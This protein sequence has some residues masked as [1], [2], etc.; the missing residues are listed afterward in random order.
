MS[1][2]K[3]DRKICLFK[4]YNSSSKIDLHFNLRFNDS[5]LE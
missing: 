3:I 5:F 1:K 4:Y 2:I